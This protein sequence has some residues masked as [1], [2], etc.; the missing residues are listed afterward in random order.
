M[1]MQPHVV[2]IDLYLYNETAGGRVPIARSVNFYTEDTIAQVLPLGD[3]S[4][5]IVVVTPWI[6]GVRLS[7]RSFVLLYG[8][9]FDW[10]VSR[11]PRLALSWP[12]TLLLRC[13]YL[14]PV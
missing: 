3:Y 6:V 9:L 4:L 12:L 8:L 14:R 10:L 13:P 11:H 2:D 5:R 1:Y 7:N